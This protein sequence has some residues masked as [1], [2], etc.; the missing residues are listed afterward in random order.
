MRFSQ[1]NPQ[2]EKTIILWMDIRQIWKNLKKKMRKSTAAERWL[3]C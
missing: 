3:E 2:L 1:H